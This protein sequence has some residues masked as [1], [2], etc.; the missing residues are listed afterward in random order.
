VDISDRLKHRRLAAH[1][2]Q[3]K[4]RDGDLTTLTRQISVED[5]LAEASDIYRLGCYL[6]GRDRPPAPA[7]ANDPEADK[8]ELHYASGVM[9]GSTFLRAG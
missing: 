2:V 9:S 8:A 1:T 6:L 7:P 5:P 3:V 4:L